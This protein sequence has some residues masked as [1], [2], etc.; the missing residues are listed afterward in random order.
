M[1]VRSD[2]MPNP[3]GGGG[4]GRHEHG[5]GPLAVRFLN[6]I[7]K[8]DQ[9]G[10]PS[11]VAL[12]QDPWVVTG[13]GPPTRTVDRHSTSRRT[14][15][16]TTN[17]SSKSVAQQ[18]APQQVARRSSRS[19]SESAQQQVADAVAAVA[20]L[21][22]TAS[23]MGVPSMHG[24]VP[25]MHGMAGKPT[26]TDT[27]TATATATVSANATAAE[28][29]TMGLG[30]AVVQPTVPTAQAVLAAGPVMVDAWATLGRGGALAT[31]L[32]AARSSAAAN[33]S[34]PDPDDDAA[35]AAAAVAPG[36]PGAVTTLRRRPPIPN[37]AEILA[38]PDPAVRWHGGVTVG[39]TDPA[40]GGTDP[41]VGGTDPAV[42]GPD[43][44]VGANIGLLGSSGPHGAGTPGPQLHQ[45]RTRSLPPILYEPPELGDEE[46]TN[47]SKSSRDLGS[48]WA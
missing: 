13:E 16:D 9:R 7:F 47:P 25:S 26:A 12:L 31:I 37:A 2:G 1:R 36:S 8:V 33:S 4:G 5:L 28:A 32:S 19:M 38:G 23:G 10:R 11:C 42:G 14:A 34:A 27:A 21:R 43:P 20:K 45:R 3:R 22:G 48:I 30:P 18:T 24:G 44:A 46:A 39:G 15:L 40:V 29:T 17:A 41:A 6:R 35:P